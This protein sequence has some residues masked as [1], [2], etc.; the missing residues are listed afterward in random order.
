MFKKRSKSNQNERPVF[1]DLGE[2][3]VSSNLNEKR[4]T[5]LRPSCFDDLVVAKNM[6]RERE[7]LVVDLSKYTGDAQIA[8][9]LLTDSA[10]DCGGRFFRI[11]ERTLMVVPF[12]VQVKDGE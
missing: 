8:S 4:V 7:I 10:C 12:D 6:L 5:V 11:N 9:N 3:P 1:I 2:F